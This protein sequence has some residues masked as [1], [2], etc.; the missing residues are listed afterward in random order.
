MKIPKLR[1]LKSTRFLIRRSINLFISNQLKGK[2]I[3][4]ILDIGAGMGPYQKLIN[5]D[6]YI[7]LDIENRSNDPNLIIG[8]LN[9]KI[10]LQNNYADGVICTEVLE[11][12]KNPQNALNE[13]YRVLK[14]D[15]FL[16]LTT[17]MTWPL[18][19]EPHDY[20]RYTKYGLKYLLE[21]A[22]FVN[23]KIEP[24]C[25]YPY[26]IAQLVVTYLRPKIY[27]PIVILINIFGVLASKFNQN[28]N[29]PLNNQV[30]AYK[31]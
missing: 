2:K 20:Y 8:D 25:C 5:Y 26:T 10:P 28:Y 31:K 24:S 27:V 12:I 6:K 30:V 19:E 9:K 22:G 1:N 18:H 14:K 21:N 15:G 17:P 29:M 3:P 13:I 4:I 23:I 11:H 7:P 16:I